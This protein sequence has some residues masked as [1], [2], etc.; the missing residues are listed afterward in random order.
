MSASHVITS[1][2]GAG[3]SWLVGSIAL[4][5]TSGYSIGSSSLAI[6]ETQML[7]SYAPSSAMVGSSIPSSTMLGSNLPSST[8]SGV[9]D[10]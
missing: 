3:G 8:M 5:I 1:G 2:Y 10:P 6:A 7:G 9:I 4:V